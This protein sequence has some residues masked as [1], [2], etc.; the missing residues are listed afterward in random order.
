ML[1]YCGFFMS[2]IFAYVKLNV[3]ADKLGI[4]IQN[5]LTNAPAEDQITD[6]VP[7]T[8]GAYDFKGATI[9]IT[10]ELISSSKKVTL[11][12]HG[13]SSW[14]KESRVQVCYFLASRNLV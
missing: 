2:S 11:V 10:E 1:K 7:V 5:S 13:L 8:G 12:R 4:R 6:H 14:N 9:S 3:C